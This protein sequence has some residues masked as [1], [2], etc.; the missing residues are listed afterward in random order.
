MAF[1]VNQR[2]REM[3]V[4]MALGAE[5]A[6]IMGL[7]L[8]KGTSQLGIGLALGL[9]GGAAMERPLR[10]VL[11]GVD[12][13]DLRVYLSIAATLLFAGF[14]ACILPARAATRV[15]PLEAMRVS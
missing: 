5:N 8:R 11:Y 4:R 1:S 3:G 15:D 14:L 9:A 7:I 10:Y 2:R 12:A 13:G 6:S